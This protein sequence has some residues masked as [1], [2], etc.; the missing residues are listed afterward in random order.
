MTIKN[1]GNDLINQDIKRLKK[2]K[3]LEK[4]LGVYF[5]YHTNLID[6]Q[7]NL[8]CIVNSGKTLQGDVYWVC[9]DRIK[10]TKPKTSNRDGCRLWF[11]VLFKP[12]VTI[13]IRILLYQA[14][15]ENQYPTSIC[16]K[17]VNERLESIGVSE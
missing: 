9:K 13:Y 12:N 17:I 8:P 7:R 4:D 5:N 16:R 3:S 10:I 2:Y 15:E 1:Y 14:R 6:E 11:M